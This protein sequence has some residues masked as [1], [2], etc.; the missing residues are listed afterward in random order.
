MTY[1]MHSEGENTITLQHVSHD[2]V[3][4]LTPRD[5]I[6]ICSHLRDNYPRGVTFI[7]VGKMPIESR[8]GLFINYR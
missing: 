7:D 2:T 5:R 8:S 3:H 6:V 1:T 4:T